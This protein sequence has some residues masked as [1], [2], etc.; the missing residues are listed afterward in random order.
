[1]KKTSIIIVLF[2]LAIL[3]CTP[4][5]HVISLKDSEAQIK[6]NG[7]IYSLPLSV[8]EMEFTVKHT[9]FTVGPYAD[10]ADKYLSI[11]GVSLADYET[12]EISGIRIN[13]VSQPDP[14]AVF[15]ICGNLAKQD[16]SLSMSKNGILHGINLPYNEAL[17]DETILPQSME[18][19]TMNQDIWFTDYTVKRNFTNIKDTTYRVIK[20]DSVYQKIP[21]I[22]N[23]I[24]SKDNEQKAEEAANFIIKTRKRRF[25][26]LTAQ[27]EKTPEGE[28]INI[29]VNELN[30]LENKYLTLFTGI[31]NSQSETFRVYYVPQK[32]DQNTILFWISDNDGVS[33]EK[34]DDAKQVSILTKNMHLTDETARFYKKQNDLKSKYTGFYYRIPGKAEVKINMD[35]ENLFNGTYD[36]AQMGTLNW[37]D[38]KMLRKKKLHIAID[39]I[40]GSLRFIN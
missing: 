19:P 14:E 33:F 16:I 37:L 7:L 13:T 9:A 40:L 3:S 22:N 4:K 25:Q 32:D 11:E 26:L 29:M 2:S 34:N 24:T 6:N 30:N 36:V 21:V 15:M 39:P 1:M 23:R 17:A 38:A 12:F 20:T 8:F 35:G 31:E 27:A 28:A 10:Y 5:M 18:F